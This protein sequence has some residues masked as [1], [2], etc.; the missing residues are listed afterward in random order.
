MFIY[1]VERNTAGS[2]EKGGN[3]QSQSWS[4]WPIA[5]RRAALGRF[6]PGEKVES[7][8]AAADKL[9]SLVVGAYRR[10]LL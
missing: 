5:K 9:L 7:I 10:I 3:T 2:R 8:V 4:V 6:V 1:L